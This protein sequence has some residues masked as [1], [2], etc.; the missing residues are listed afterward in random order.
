MFKPLS[1]L[2]ITQEG[3]LPTGNTGGGLES[4]VEDSQAPAAAKGTGKARRKG[5]AKGTSRATPAPRAGSQSGDEMG[6]HA[7]GGLASGKSTPQPE[8][9]RR[10]YDSGREGDDEYEDAEAEPDAFGYEAGM[11]GHMLMG[12]L[13]RFE[14]SIAELRTDLM[15]E[16]MADREQDRKEADALFKRIISAVEGTREGVNHSGGSKQARKRKGKASLISQNKM[17]PRKPILKVRHKF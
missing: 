12:H 4:E 2:M 9:T 10:G 17:N 14:S 1:R 7:S 8:H 16:R 6:Q 3:S 13:N 5:K 15:L 11:S